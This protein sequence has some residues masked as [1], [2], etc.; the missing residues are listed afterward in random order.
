MTIKS[1]VL[2]VF[3]FGLAG[4]QPGIHSFVNRMDMPAVRTYVE[5]G[6][7]INVRDK[8]GATPICQAA[9]YG[10][11]G[12]VSYLAQNGADVNIPNESGWTPICY[13]AYYDHLPC[14]KALLDA[15]ADPNL[16]NVHGF[17]ALYY[18]K[19]LKFKEIET[20]LLQNGATSDF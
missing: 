5:S 8:H 4:C 11:C 20:L 12:I 2:I 14:V 3:L 18:A 1:A 10:Y 9:Y 15:G 13:A 19:T 6:N 7:D 16:T 17:N